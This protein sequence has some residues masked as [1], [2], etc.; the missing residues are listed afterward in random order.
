VVASVVAVDRVE[1]SWKAPAGDDIGGYFVERAAVEVWTE[2]QLRRLKGQTPPL[3]EPSVGAV[4]RMGGFSRVHDKPL[5]A[6]RFTDAVDLSKPSSIAGEAVYENRM[7][8]EQ[9][10]SGG[11]DYRYAVLAYRVRVV[12]RSGVESGPSPYVLTIPSAPQSVFSRERGSQCELKW[13]KNPEQRIAGYRVYRMNGR[14]DKDPIERHNDTPVAET[15]Y[16]D[17]EAG[18]STRRYYVVAVDAL[19]QEGIPSAPVW[20]EREWKSFYKPFTSDWHQ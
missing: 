5:P 16:T 20:F 4:R 17:A 15:S 3:R 9:V 18:K 2:D 13:A 7:S 11:R 12:N 10:D 19:G 14:Y 1:L 8:S 6:P